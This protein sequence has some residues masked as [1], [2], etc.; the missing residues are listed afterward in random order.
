MDRAICW[1]QYAHNGMYHKTWCLSRK[2]QIYLNLLWKNVALLLC[3][4]A[5]YFVQW[6]KWECEKH[7]RIKP[8]YFSILLHNADVIGFFQELDLWRSEEGS[9]IVD[10]AQTC[11][12]LWL[13][14]EDEPQNTELN[15][16]VVFASQHSYILAELNPPK[17]TFNAV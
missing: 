10:E 6:Q 2:Q 4:S 14:S 9:L 7:A 8:T 1:K 16:E 13:I 11:V 3:N 12:P 15:T 17:S 5:E